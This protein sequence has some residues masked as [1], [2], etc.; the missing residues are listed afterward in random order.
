MMGLY[1][2]TTANNLNEW[3]QGNAIP[4]IA[5]ADFMEW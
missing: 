5:G 4:P 1:P 3:Q 2:A